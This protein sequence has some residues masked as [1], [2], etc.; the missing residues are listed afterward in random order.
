MS[1]PRGVRTGVAVVDARPHGVLEGDA[2]AVP[3]AGIGGTGLQQR[4]WGEAA[5]LEP[6]AGE[7]AFLSNVAAFAK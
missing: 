1:R 4:R 6:V 3:G 7:R 2:A 5:G